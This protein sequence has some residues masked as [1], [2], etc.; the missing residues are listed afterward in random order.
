MKRDV[1]QNA[2]PQVR[3]AL[4]YDLNKIPL[5]KLVYILLPQQFVMVYTKTGQEAEK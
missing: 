1:M 2:R 5:N 3:F 4:I